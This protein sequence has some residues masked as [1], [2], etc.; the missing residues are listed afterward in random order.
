[1]DT[2]TRLETVAGSISDSA[3]PLLKSTGYKAILFK[4]HRYIM[5]YRV[6]NQTA[7]VEAIYHQLQDYEGIFASE[8]E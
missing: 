8:I 3:H 2:A 6:E 7:F 5:L 1:M 4:N